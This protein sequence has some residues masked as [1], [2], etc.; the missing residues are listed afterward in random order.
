MWLNDTLTISFFTALFLQPPLYHFHPTCTSSSWPSSPPI[1][2]IATL[3]T[4][5]C[6]HHRHRSSSP[7]SLLPI[8]I[9]T[10]VAIDLRR[11]HCRHRSSW[12][13]LSSSIFV[14]AID[15]RCR[16]LHLLFTLTLS[17]QPVFLVAAAITN[18]LLCHCC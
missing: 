14:V 10:A 13:P 6:C 5:L 2:V 18:L 15:L 9:I 1:F 16:H 3:T 12:P 7:P 4:D 11:R 17:S 8:F